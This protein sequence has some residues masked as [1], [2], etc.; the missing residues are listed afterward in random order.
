MYLDWL[1][2][3]ILSLFIL[4]L[5]IGLIS[6]YKEKEIFNRFRHLYIRR[7]KRIAQIQSKYPHAL[8]K[9]CQTNGFIYRK[10][11]FHYNLKT[12]LNISKIS[13]NIWEMAQNVELAVIENEYKNIKENYPD[14]LKAAIDKYD[15]TNV[16][17]LLKLKPFIVHQQRLYDDEQMFNECEAQQIAFSKQLTS[18]LND[19]HKH[20]YVYNLKSYVFNIGLRK[21]DRYEVIHDGKYDVICTGQFETSSRNDIDLS[22]LPLDWE[23]LRNKVVNKEYKDTSFC[24]DAPIFGLV[25]SINKDF[26]S[27]ITFV[28]GNIDKDTISDLTK[29][30]SANKYSDLIESLQSEGID[31]ISM[32]HLFGQNRLKHTKVIIISDVLVSSQL[33]DVI[34]ELQK[35]RMREKLCIGCI[36]S[37]INHDT[38]FAKRLLADYR[39]RVQVQNAIHCFHQAFDDKDI[40]D[41]KKYYST[42]VELIE[43]DKKL[44]VF[45][46]ALKIIKEKYSEFE[47]EY[48]EGIVTE[49]NI[50]TVNYLVPNEYLHIDTKVYYY[51]AFPQQGTKIFPF[52]RRKVNR[53]GY[54]EELF[55]ETLHKYLS[56]TRI[57]S[58]AAL[59]VSEY[60]QYEPDIAL[61]YD[62]KYHI[63]IDIEIDEPY[64]GYDRKP[65]HCKG[66][67]S[68]AYRDLIL[69]KAGW[70]VIRFAEEQVVKSPLN[71]ALIIARLLNSIDKNYC[72]NK[73]IFADIEKSG[74]G[75]NLIP[76]WANEDAQKMAAIHYREQY[77]NIDSFGKV[78][79]QDRSLSECKLTEYER[80][81]SN[82]LPSVETCPEQFVLDEDKKHNKTIPSLPHKRT[83]AEKEFDIAVSMPC[84]KLANG[85]NDI[86]K[87]DQ[88]VKF[89]SNC[90]SLMSIYQIMRHYFI[91]IDHCYIARAKSM[92]DRAI[93]MQIL[94]SL[95]LEDARREFIYSQISN[96]VQGRVDSGVFDIKYNGKTFYNVDITRELTLIKQFVSS[97]STNPKIAGIEITDMPH[98]IKGQIGCIYDDELY[99]FDIF[100]EYYGVDRGK[101]ILSHIGD[102]P[103]ERNDM[104]VSFKAYLVE[105]HLGIKINKTY[106]VTINAKNNSYLVRRARRR[107]S[108]VQQVFLDL[109]RN[110]I[111]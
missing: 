70:I 96:V 68:D 55:E 19:Q 20:H 94:D 1:I 77:L 65:I 64:S 84:P 43:S 54:S 44:A 12:A 4:L 83:K 66:N 52:R 40:D 10:D 22:E 95:E 69:V 28:I 2:A 18:Y 7:Y 104:I 88:V 9:Y 75:F 47:G 49:E 63:N 101:S 110:P 71:C 6:E 30:D 41:I 32:T 79:N 91:A 38:V 26:A 78:E 76:K 3:I 48:S 98:M 103:N 86:A 90:A 25:R 99:D 27:D 37:I 102:V 46:P 5:L 61:I 109:N 97:K 17:D 24:L 92:G 80:K 74:E 107:T 60:R 56:N 58:D 31:A 16:E 33:R 13:D 72:I 21:I 105:Q 59:Y 34:K 81:I 15:T 87:S 42:A 93:E 53:R 108:E 73:S 89:Q 35:C 85:R 111:G 23:I 106:T 45:L 82:E 29:S 39:K 8:K 57:V 36:T 100:T 67:Q 50:N 14:G 51:V 62:N 11:R